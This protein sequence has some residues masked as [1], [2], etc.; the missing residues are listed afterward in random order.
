ML[1][2]HQHGQ[3]A[4]EDLA[5]TPTAHQ[6]NCA[7]PR[8]ASVYGSTLQPQRGAKNVPLSASFLSPDWANA[9][10]TSLNHTYLSLPTRNISGMHRWRCKNQ[11]GPAAYLTAGGWG[12]GCKQTP[13]ET[14]LYRPTGNQKDWSPAT[15]TAK[16]SQA[17]HTRSNSKRLIG[18]TRQINRG[19]ARRQRRF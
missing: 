4:S 17:K 13:A 3:W 1:L 12:G 8:H 18:S 6:T 2:K 10:P 5:R 7:N 19:R 9:L 11:N 14:L 15:K 16:V